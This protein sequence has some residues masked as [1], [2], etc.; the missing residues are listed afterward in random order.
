MVFRGGDMGNKQGRL[1]KDTRLGRLQPFKFLFVSAPSISRSESR[2]ALSQV[3]LSFVFFFVAIAVG[4]AAID[5]SR[6]GGDAMI[7]FWMLL[8]LAFLSFSYAVGLGIHWVKKDT[9]EGSKE[10]ELRGVITTLAESI[11]KS[12]ETTH[13]DIQ[14]LVDEIRQDRD[15]RKSKSG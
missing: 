8:G 6:V 14:S 11:S 15:E 9:R 4:I 5:I 3:V 10:D 12:T 2:W 1:F 13:N 7:A